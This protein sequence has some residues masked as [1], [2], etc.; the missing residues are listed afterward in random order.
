MCSTLGFVAGGSIHN[1]LSNMP[2]QNS[3]IAITLRNPEAFALACKATR[4]LQFRA[5]HRITGAEQTHT[6]HPP[7]AFIGWSPGAGI[8]LDDPSISQCHAYLQVIE[9]DLFCIDLGSRTGVIWDDGSQGRGWVC[10]GQSLRIGM[11]DVQIETPEGASVDRSLE[12]QRDPDSIAG[13][14]L[15]QA[16]VEIHSTTHTVNGV[17]SLDRPIMLLGRH[18]TC[19]LR[20]L[21]ESIA[22]FQ[23]ALVNTADGVWFVDALSRGGAVLNGRNIRLARLRDAYLLEL[24]KVSLVFRIGANSRWSP[25][26]LLEP[27]ALPTASDA[28]ATISGKVAEAVAGAFVPVGEMLNQ[29]Q[30]CFVSMTQMFTSMQQEHA[31]VVSEQIRLIQELAGEVRELRAKVHGDNP[32]TIATTPSPATLPA[33]PPVQPPPA[34][35]EPVTPPLRSPSPSLSPDNTQTLSDA[36][37]WFMNRLAKKGQAPPAGS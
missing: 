35:T 33:S 19:E 34:T 12:E 21:D 20:L 9:G 32:A 15:S 8:R 2:T 1:Q 18:P 6:F 30:K 26:T 16:S 28:V 29:F 37:S 36:H 11:F 23:C 10:A 24:G 7:F 4:P 25:I 3:S 14:D 17:H 13:P 27:I 22:Y 31:T 5:K